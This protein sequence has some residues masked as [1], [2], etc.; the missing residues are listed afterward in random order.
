[1]IDD[2]CTRCQI[3]CKAGFEMAVWGR[4][5]KIDHGVSEMAM[6]KQCII[7]SQRRLLFSLESNS[8]LEGRN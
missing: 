6:H 7:Q 3:S 1:M 2:D 8:S 5:E 4:R